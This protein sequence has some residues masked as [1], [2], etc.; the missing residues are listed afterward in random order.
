MLKKTITYENFDGEEVTEDFYFHLTKAE[1]VELEMSKP[2]GLA[3]YMQ[4]LIEK[5]DRAGIIQ[6]MKEL[7]LSSYGKRDAVKKQFVKNPVMRDEFEASE[8]YSELF[9]EL[10]TK[11]DAS[12]EFMT[13]VIPAG[14]AKQANLQELVSNET[15]DAVAP[16]TEDRS[17]GVIKV[18]H[19]ELQLMD[20]EAFAR[21]MRRIRTGQV[22]LVE[23]NG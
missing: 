11:P 9:M 7:I 3:D 17:E 22:E 21:T 20:S 16:Q 5:D 15:V 14:L 1:L 6:T 4:K 8:A 23:E 19:T 2:G 18:T 13:G 10:V 12:L